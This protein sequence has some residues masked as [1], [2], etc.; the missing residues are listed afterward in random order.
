MTLVFSLNYF[1]FN[2]L[3]PSP[4]CGGAAA[5]VVWATVWDTGSVME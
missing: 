5:G 1:E 4:A 3:I 2:F